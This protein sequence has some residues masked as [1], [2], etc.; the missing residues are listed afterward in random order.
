MLNNYASV[1]C[2]ETKGNV[3]LYKGPCH[4]CIYYFRLAGFV[5]FVPVRFV[6]SSDLY[7]VFDGVGSEALEGSMIKAAAPDLYDLFR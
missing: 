3:T 1:L 7:D 5:R 2:I 4:I 6:T